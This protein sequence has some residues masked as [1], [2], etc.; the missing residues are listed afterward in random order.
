MKDIPKIFKLFDLTGRNIIVT[1]S[2]GILGSQYADTLSQAG[3]NVILV[4]INGKN[5]NLE[6]TL[7]KKYKTNAKFYCADI[8]IEKNV[9][10]L[11]KNILKDFKK[12]DGLINNAAYTNIT[13]I[14]DSA[15]I[16]APFEK[17]SFKVWKK[18]LDVNL[19]SVF[20]CC[21]VFGPQMVKQRKGTIVNVA[22]IYGMVGTDQRIY[23]N[24]KINS[25]AP[26]AAA[27]GGIIN[28]TRYLAAYW[29]KKNIR[30]N[31]L[32]PGG[33]LDKK[34]QKQNFI[35]KYS[36]KTILGRMASRD[37]YN[38]AIL[39]LMSDASSYMTGSNLVIDGGWT[40]W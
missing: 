10:S 27:K 37:E 22:S 9:L 19:S 40:A 30:V 39:F 26:Y 31:T 5:N 17:F 38:G 11:K 4:D 34:F 21:K 2:S 28:L 14:K 6:K 7:R 25:P 20:N 24:S 29:H 1:G 12:I 13:A 8:S 3:A 18:M 16:F 33:V 23:G 32:T 15:N 35:E 36:R